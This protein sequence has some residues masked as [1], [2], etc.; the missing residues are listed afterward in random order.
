MFCHVGGGGYALGR[1]IA[2]LKDE[3][4]RRLD[5]GDTMMTMKVGGVP[6]AENLKRA[7]GFGLGGAELDGNYLI[8]SDRPGAALRTMR[9]L[10]T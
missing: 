4:R 9:T 10:A 6:L 7:A 5:A 8:L 2:D 1:T 3:M